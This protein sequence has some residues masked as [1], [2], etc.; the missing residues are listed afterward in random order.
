MC[1]CVCVCACVC[2]LCVH[3]WC[4]VCVHV[5]SECVACIVCMHTYILMCILCN[6]HT[7][8]TAAYVHM[9]DTLHILHYTT[10]HNRGQTLQ[11]TV[12]GRVM[13]QMA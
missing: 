1:V 12:E 8:T 2:V 13:L 3:V 10:L 11:Y 5:C 4:V 7:R 6:T 9:H